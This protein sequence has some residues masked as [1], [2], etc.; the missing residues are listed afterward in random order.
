MGI[1]SQYHRLK[2]DGHLDRAGIM[3]SGMCAM[4]CLAS[5][6]LVAMLGVAGGVLIDHSIHQVG[7]V[8][9]IVLGIGSIGLG[10]LDHGF[11]MPVSIGS[12]GIGVMAGALSLPHNS[13]ETIYTIIGVALLSLGHDLNR[14]AAR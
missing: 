10:A 14:R 13:S 1:T 5:A 9:A 7:I 6:L 8:L 2:Q 3:L 12:L 11:M 4:H